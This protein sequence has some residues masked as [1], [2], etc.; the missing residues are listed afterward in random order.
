MEKIDSKIISGEAAK[1]A[2]VFGA[3]SGGYIFVGGAMSQPE[4]S[5]LVNILSVI[6]WAGKLVGCILL[7]RYFM[8]KL[9]GSYEG[10]TR[11]NLLA[12]GTLI[13]L[14]SAIITAACSYISVQYVFPGQ[15]KDSFDTAF[16]AYSGMLDS[17]AL[18]S[19]ESVEGN[20]GVISLV[21]NL[22]WCF[23]YGWILSSIMSSSL[24]GSSKKN[25]FDDDDI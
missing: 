10:V 25:I 5:I 17:N 15:I 14:F 16:Q 9:M 1:V 19:I 21:S 11:Q 13:A 3:I 20:F 18:S 23:V 4:T 12:Y 7:M 8:K 6:L 22:I 2:L 24:A